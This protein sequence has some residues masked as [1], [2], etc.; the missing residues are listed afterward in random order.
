MRRE[1]PTSADAIVFPVL[2]KLWVGPLVVVEGA[3]ACACVRC[4]AES[5]K[6]RTTTQVSTS[7]VEV[8]KNGST[9]KY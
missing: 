7:S 5:L 2:T 9:G 4:V 1:G 6:R 3:R 8:K